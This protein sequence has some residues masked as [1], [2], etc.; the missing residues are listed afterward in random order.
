MADQK[1]EGHQSR[2]NQYL[3]KLG[4]VKII[5]IDRMTYRCY[6]HTEFVVSP[7]ASQVVWPITRER[8]L[9]NHLGE[10]SRPEALFA[11]FQVAAS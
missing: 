10:I 5:A 1:S 9:T 6:D 8:L 2:K 4:G 3:T 7:V 11:A